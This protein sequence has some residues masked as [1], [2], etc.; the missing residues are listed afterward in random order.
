MSEKFK[1]DADKQIAAYR[2]AQPRHIRARIE[3]ALL[4]A[5]SSGLREEQREYWRYIAF[6][7]SEILLTTA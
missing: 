3:S 6:G 4:Q 2:G 1:A 7:C 5:E